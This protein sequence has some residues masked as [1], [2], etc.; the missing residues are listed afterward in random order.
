MDF[1]ELPNRPVNGGIQYVAVFP[2]GKGASIVKHNFSYVN[3][4]GLWEHAVL[5]NI[6]GFYYLEIFF[7]QKEL[8]R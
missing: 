7:V 1:K 5:K 6:K 4:V 3:K 2:N 8:K